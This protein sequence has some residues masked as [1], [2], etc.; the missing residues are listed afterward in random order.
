MILWQELSGDECVLAV[1]AANPR[2][3]LASVWDNATKH[4]LLTLIYR[5]RRSGR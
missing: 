5:V 1:A 3:V 4:L 2:H